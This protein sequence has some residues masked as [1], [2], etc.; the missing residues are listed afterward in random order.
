MICGVTRPPGIGL[1]SAF[2]ETNKTYKVLIE[3]SRDK[4]T[5]TP[6]I[7]L[8]AGESKKMWPEANQAQTI[9]LG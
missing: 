3:A 2:E 9:R 5:Q 4:I 8:T 6:K 1:T 7:T